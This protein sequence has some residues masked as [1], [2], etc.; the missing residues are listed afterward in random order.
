MR[1]LRT[2][3]LSIAMVIGI[4]LIAHSM[5]GTWVV[6]VWPMVVGAGLVGLVVD[7]VLSDDR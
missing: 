7:Y 2:F 5:S 4:A 6:N 1:S 3:G